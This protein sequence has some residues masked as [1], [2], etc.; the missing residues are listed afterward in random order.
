MIDQKERTISEEKRAYQK[1]D[2]IDPLP[3]I[4]ALIDECP[5]YG[6]RWIHRLLARHRIREW[7]DSVNQKLVYRIIKRHRLLLPRH[8]GPRVPMTH[9]G[10]ERT[11][12][13]NQRLSSDEFE[14][15]CPN[16][17]TVRVAFAPDFCDQEAPGYVATTIGWISSSLTRDLMIQALAN[18]FGRPE[19]LLHPV[20]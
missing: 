18:C 15:P 16:R 19:R 3:T 5:S 20:E 4:R 12:R 6:Y 9:E 2:D 11:P 13:S 14:I 10:M 1:T 8:S 17:E 7:K